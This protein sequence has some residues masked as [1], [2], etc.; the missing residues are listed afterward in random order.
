MRFCVDNLAIFA[1]K[2]KGSFHVQFSLVRGKKAKNGGTPESELEIEGSPAIQ[3][4]NICMADGYVSSI[5]N[6]TSLRTEGTPPEEEG[7]NRGFGCQPASRFLRA[8]HSR[9]T[10]VLTSNQC[11]WVE[12]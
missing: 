4:K 2:L 5:L 10:Q 3:T 6:G 8:P 7:S 1:F 12:I 11:G 9:E